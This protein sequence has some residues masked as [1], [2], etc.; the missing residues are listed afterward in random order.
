MVNLLPI[1]SGKGGVGKSSFSVNLAVALARKGKSVVLADLDFGGANL[2]TLLGLK[3][4]HIGLGNYI[5]KQT[6]DFNSLLQ[7]TQIPNLKFIAGDCLFPGTA[8]MELSAK[9]RIIKSLN[10]LEADYVIMDLGAG[11]TYNTLDFFL[12]TYNSIMIT[13]PEL[14]SVLNAYSFLKAAAF[15]F[16]M[17]QFKAKSEERLFINNFLKNSLTG[18]EASFFT[19]INQIKENYPESGVKVLEEL[20]KYR[21]QIIINMGQVSSDLEMAK[22]FRKLVFDKLSIKM[23]FV[24]FLPR[25]ERVGY[26]VALR[27][28]LLLTNPTCK[29]AESVNTSAE[30]IIQHSYKI[31]ELNEYEDDDNNMDLNTLS[32]EFNK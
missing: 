32:S 29:F 28:P 25:D 2:H 18:T 31:N 16:L 14:T 26:S 9:R 6:E 13:T 22:K 4:N 21:P 30:K 7:D 23:D 27:S 12:L 1:A 19:L 11:T 15:R 20:E 24:G 8:N 17:R 5:Y 10:A 3:N